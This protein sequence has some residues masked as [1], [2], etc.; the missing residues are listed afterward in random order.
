M[1]FIIEGKEY[2][3]DQGMAKVTLQT[4]FELKAKHG[5]SAKDLQGMAGYLQKFNGKDPAELLDDKVALRGLMVVIWLARKHAG[6][7]LSMEEANSFPMDQFLIKPEEPVADD[8]PK[9]ATPPDSE[10][11]ARAPQE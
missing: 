2:D 8:D 5:I 1:I 10:A 3:V 6:E 7:K 9:E 11:D 4:L